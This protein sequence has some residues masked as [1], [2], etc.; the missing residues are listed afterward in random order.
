MKATLI[1]EEAF[2]Y[3]VSIV[4]RKVQASIITF[5]FFTIDMKANISSLILILWKNTKKMI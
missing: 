3:I 4:S 2:L 1:F 5:D